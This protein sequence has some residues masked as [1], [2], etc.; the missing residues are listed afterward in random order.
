MLT[1][2]PAQ[3]VVWRNRT[4]PGENTQPVPLSFPVE[5]LGDFSGL[6][7]WNHGGKCYELFLAEGTTVPTQEDLNRLVQHT[8][9]IYNIDVVHGVTILEEA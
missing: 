3:L 7:K 2:E 1:V 9:S 4:P 6:V 5:H 8:N